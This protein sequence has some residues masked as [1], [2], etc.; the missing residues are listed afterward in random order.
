MANY[1]RQALSRKNC[2]CRRAIINQPKC[3][4]IQGNVCKAG[5][6][7][8]VLILRKQFYSQ[9]SSFFALHESDT[10]SGD[11]GSSSGLPR[12]TSYKT[13]GY[14][15]DNDQPPIGPFEGCVPVCRLCWAFGGCLLG[16]IIG[17]VG[18]YRHRGWLALAGYALFIIGSGVWLTRHSNCE[19]QNDN[20]SGYVFLHNGEN[21]SQKLLTPQVFL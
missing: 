12:L 15:G 4:V 3:G 2:C 8:R 11:L 1:S 14:S 13:T 20:D 19:A 7:Q 21:V 6:T 17:V 9:P 10:V 16:I 5:N 18:I